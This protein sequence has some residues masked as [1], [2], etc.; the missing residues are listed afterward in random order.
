MDMVVATL[1]NCYAAELENKWA[2]ECLVKLLGAEILEAFHHVHEMC[3][4]NGDM[5]IVT[6]ILEPW[7]LDEVSILP[8]RE[9]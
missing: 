1:V 6:E 2:I 3:G 9:W 8:A 7:S 5:H 4:P